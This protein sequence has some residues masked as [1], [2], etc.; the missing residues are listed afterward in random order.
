LYIYQ[1]LPFLSDCRR[2]LKDFGY[3][4]ILGIPDFEMTARLYLTKIH[5]GNTFAEPF[6][7]YQAYRLT[8]GDFE[9]GG[10]AYIPQMHK[11]LFDKD[12]V[13][14]LF[15]FVDFQHTRIFNYVF[16]GEN[17]VSA[18]GAVASK[19]KTLTEKETKKVLF[20]FKTYFENLDDVCV[21]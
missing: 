2:I 11:T 20:E 17:Q 18:I 10:K 13:F 19:F 6:N 15:N 14:N 4:V 5:S 7:L 3:L 12:S 8:H 9:G 16:P 21:S 1:Q